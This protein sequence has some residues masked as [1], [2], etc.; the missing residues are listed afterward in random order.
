MRKPRFKKS[1]MPGGLP[2]MGTVVSASKRRGG[3]LYKYPNNQEVKHIA[4]K[5]VARYY[6]RW[7][8]DNHKGKIVLF[9]PIN[10]KLDEREYANPEEFQL[11]VDMLRNEK[12]LWF[13]PDMMQL[14]TGW[15]ATGETVGEEESQVGKN[16][17]LR[18]KDNERY[19]PL[20]FYFSVLSLW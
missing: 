3:A 9:D 10:N 2:N 8:L 12:P 15:G 20:S 14:R 5:A 6:S 19:Y 7:D 17:E 4:L 18:S 1:E 16:K 13:N 11:I